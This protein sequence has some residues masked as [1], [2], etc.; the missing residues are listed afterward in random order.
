MSQPAKHF[1]FVRADVYVQAK[2]TD[3]KGFFVD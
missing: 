3:Y 2:N 1:P